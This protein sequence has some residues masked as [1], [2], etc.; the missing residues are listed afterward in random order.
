MLRLDYGSGSKPKKGF[1]SSDF[2]GRPGFDYYIQNYKIS[3]IEDQTVDEIHCR[4]V[5]HHIPEND[6]NLLFAE[7]ERIIKPNG[8][9]VISEPREEYFVQNK[10]LDIIWYRWISTDYSIKLPENYY[11]NYKKYLKKFK[12]VKKYNDEKN[13]VILLKKAY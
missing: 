12:Q 1:K 8:K 6:L 11:V 10:I 9:I 2:I 5:I 7:F 3:E 13:E 4:N